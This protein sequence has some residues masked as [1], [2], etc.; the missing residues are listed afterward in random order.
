[1]YRSSSGTLDGTSGRGTPMSWSV[2]LGKLHIAERLAPLS[3]DVRALV[4]LPSFEQ[5]K[6]VLQAEPAQD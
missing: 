1:M 5:L 4:N 3:R 2:V 6:A